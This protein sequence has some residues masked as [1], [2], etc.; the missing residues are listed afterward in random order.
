MFKNSKLNVTLQFVIY[1]LIS[2]CIVLAAILCNS[3]WL[4]FWGIAIKIPIW[5]FY[6]W[7]PNVHSKSSTTCSI[8]LA[9]VILKFSSLILVRSEVQLISASAH[10][11]S[12]LSF[13][14]LCAAC[15]M[16]MHKNIKT[17]I[18]YSSIIHMGMYL[19]VLPKLQ[20]FTFCLL[21]HSIAISLA[22][23]TLDKIKSQ[24]ETLNTM[25]LK[26]CTKDW[27]LLMIVILN[28]IGV[29][30]TYGFISEVISIIYITRYSIVC[31]AI[32][33]ISLLISSSYL[34]SS[35][36]MI[37]TIPTNQRQKSNIK[38][39]CIIYTLLLIIFVIGLFPKIFYTTFC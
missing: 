22:F 30:F 27:I 7:L 2:A 21:Q 1:T 13:G 18:A 35:L 5:P 11:H 20:D 28:L 32:I 24:Y 33:A 25:K 15:Q 16:C 19:F 3:A 29:P 10:F 9:S 36:F 14:I 26:L 6:Y 8:L 4:L 34:I 17:I 38:Q 12:L 31:A 23:F 39:D 37:E